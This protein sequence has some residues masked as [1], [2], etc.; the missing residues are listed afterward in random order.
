MCSHIWQ[1]CLY[2]LY[3]RTFISQIF[4]WLVVQCTFMYVCMYVCMST[5]WG[6]GAGDEADHGFVFIAVSLRN[7]YMQ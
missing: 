2:F 1:V 3:V 7:E 5:W 4:H 6:T